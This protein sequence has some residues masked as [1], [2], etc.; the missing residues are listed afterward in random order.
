MTQMTTVTIDL[1]PFQGTVSSFHRLD[2][3]NERS[4]RTLAGC[5]LRDGPP[6]HNAKDQKGGDRR[7]IEI[8]IQFGFPSRC[9]AA[10]RFA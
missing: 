5:A 10:L 7:R 3:G 1:H 9:H 8:R 4:S 6:S 2:Q